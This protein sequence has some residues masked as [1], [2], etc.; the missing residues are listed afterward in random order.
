VDGARR[1]DAFVDE[2][3]TAI[4][5]VF[6]AVFTRPFLS[7]VFRPRLLRASVR[8]LTISD[9]RKQLI[10]CFTLKSKTW[11]LS[12]LRE[13]AM[14]RHNGSWR[15]VITAASVLCILAGTSSIAFG[16]Y[17]FVQ[18]GDS[19]GAWDD[20]ANWLDGG[21]NTTYPNAVGA[22]VLMVEPVKSGV[23]AYTL[24]MPAT[25]VKVGQ[26]TIDNTTNNYMY[27]TQTILENNG[28]SR[29]IFEDS[30]GTAK[31]IETLNTNTAP[32]NIQNSIRPPILLNSDL[33]IT[34]NNYLNLN[35]GTIFTNR[36]D[37]ASNRKIIKKGVGGIQFNLNSAPGAG[38]GFFGTIEIQEGAIRLIN[39]TFS[40]ATASG[41]TVSNGGQL[42]LADNNNQAVPIYNIAAGAV[43]NLNGVGTLAPSSG[44][45]GALR[46]G[47]QGGRTTTFQSPV[48]LQT[49]SVISVGAANSIGV[50]DQAVSGAGSLIK[51]G[52]GKLVLSNAS[53]SWA[54]DTTVLAE[55][56]P[57]TATSVLSLTNPTLA[58]GRD[59]YLSATRTALDLNFTV[60]QSIDAVR[61]LYLDNV[62]QPIGLYGPVG[63]INSTDTEVAWITGNGY[64]NVS[65]QPG[66]GVPGDFNNNGSVDAGDYVLWRKGGPLQNEVDTPGTVNGQD[67]LDWRARFG[68]PP[69]SGSGGSLGAGAVPEPAT[70]VLLALIVPFIG[71]RIFGRTRS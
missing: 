42:Q 68:N 51:R 9:R 60:P 62:A 32:Q 69:G 2:I 10:C 38:L 64:L 48:V 58:N 59:V 54:G 31:Y 30:S 14:A 6:A 52:D 12:Q 49:D 19:V 20:V 3:V 15:I 4:K 33:E 40:I 24:T 1:I 28:G 63:S 11:D 66:V 18:D 7:G 70:L 47:I 41:I 13:S 35:T 53:N 43:L 44:P 65:T 55:P 36:I 57:S 27:T 37:A 26:F 46:F 50:I 21:S 61:A 39:Q 17:T 23:G 25:D 67:Y 29:L 45:Q 34:Q 56:T 8:I 71:R 5:V 22:T 16:Q